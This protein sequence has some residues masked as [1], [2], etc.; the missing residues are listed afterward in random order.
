MSNSRGFRGFKRAALISE[1]TYKNELENVDLDLVVYYSGGVYRFRKESGRS[2]V[3]KTVTRKGATALKNVVKRAYAAGVDPGFTPSFCRDAFFLHM[4]SKPTVYYLLRKN[5]RGE[6]EFIK[7]VPADCV[8]ASDDNLKSFSK[9][10]IKS[11][12]KLVLPGTRSEKPA[13]PAPEG[14]VT[15][16]STDVA[17]RE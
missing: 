11:G 3:L 12:M 4:G 9:R 14:D 2:A 17:I 8:D 7:D 1:E 13:L 10:G 6:L 16:T 5:E 15:S